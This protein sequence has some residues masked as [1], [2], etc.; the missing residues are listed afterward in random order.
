MKTC[1]KDS[2]DFCSHFPYSVWCGAGFGS[3]PGLAAGLAGAG[4]P[5]LL[6]GNC[7]FSIKISAAL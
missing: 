6:R 4:V 2:A 5:M 7:K 1:I 3:V